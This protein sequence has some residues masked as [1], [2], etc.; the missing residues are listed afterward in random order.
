MSDGIVS[1][2]NYTQLGFYRVGDEYNEPLTMSEMLSSL[3]EWFAARISLEDTLLWDD[4]TPGYSHRKKVYLKS[5]KVDP[6]TGD[7][8]LILWRAV[9]NGDGV[10]GIK[11]DASLDDSQLYDADAAADGERVIWGEASYYWFIPS[12]DIFASIRFPKSVADTEMLHRYFRDFIELHSNIRQKVRE[13]KTGVQGAY[14][15]IH[16]PPKTPGET[17]RLWLRIRSRQYTKLTTGADLSKIAKDIT[18]FVYREV[19]SARANTQKDWTRYFGHLPFI[20]GTVEKETRK[21]EVNIEAKPTV[22]E[23]RKIFENYAA[24]YGLGKDSWRNIGFRKDGVG[25]ICWLNSFVIKNTLPVNDSTA[26]GRD[27][28]GHYTVDRLFNALTFTRDRLLAPFAATE[29]GAIDVPEAEAENQVKN[30]I[31]EE[32]HVS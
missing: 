5:I 17:G 22:A 6:D 11:A 31:N 21:V 12:L 1:F 23:L 9:G 18:H 29:A 28:N 30:L 26:G 32:S 2:F 3:H 8:M 19:I 10:Y 4:E 25:G 27:D 20:S 15:S 24:E 16:F 14:I 7:Y 13:E